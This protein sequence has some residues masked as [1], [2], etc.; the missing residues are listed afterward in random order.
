[1]KW[2]KADLY[3]PVEADD[4][5]HWSQ[6]PEGTWREVNGTFS[7][8]STTG[9]PVITIEYAPRRYSKD[10]FDERQY[11]PGALL[12]TRPAKYRTHKVGGT[13]KVGDHIKVG[14]DEWV[15][16]SDGLEEI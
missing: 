15:V 9:E 6:V 2:S 10:D 16:H 14:R 4:E 13:F 8:T 11:A 3:D 1:M 7:E 12:Q 5:E